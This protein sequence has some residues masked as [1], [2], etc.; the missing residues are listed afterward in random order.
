MLSRFGYVQLIFLGISE[1]KSVVY[2]NVLYELEFVWIE[3]YMYS[4]QIP[5]KLVLLTR[6]T[7]ENTESHINRAVELCDWFAI[8]QGLKQG[9]R[10]AP[11]LFSMVLEHV[12]KKYE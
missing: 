7:M 5:F 3:F 6:S 11:M 1:K 8:K 4:V 12:I 9:D 10:L 2:S